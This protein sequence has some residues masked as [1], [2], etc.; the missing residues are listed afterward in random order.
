MIKSGWRQLSWG[1]GYG[2][3]RYNQ[4]WSSIFVT[5]LENLTNL[6]KCHYM[7]WGLRSTNIKKCQDTSSLYFELFPIKPKILIVVVLLLVVKAIWL[8]LYFLNSNP[9]LVG[10][11]DRE[12]RGFPW[13]LYGALGDQGRHVDDCVVVANL[14]WYQILILKGGIS[15]VY[16]I[17][18]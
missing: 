18:I 4:S 6:W 14:Q 10:F 9:G 7:D 16:D 13:C 12:C 11:T 2:D 17:T 1:W 5:I 3:N 15:T 8:Q